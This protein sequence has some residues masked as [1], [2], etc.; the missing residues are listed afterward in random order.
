M[1]AGLRDTDPMSIR[2]HLTA[3][4]L[5][6]ATG[7]STCAF[8]APAAPTPGTD[9]RRKVPGDVLRA[10]QSTLP[11]GRRVRRALLSPTFDPNL[12]VSAPTSV[13]V[14]FLWDAASF[15]NAFGYFTWR[16]GGASGSNIEILDR[17][18]VFA[19]ASRGALRPGDAVKLRDADGNVR[20]FE[21][22]TR[23]GFFV[24]ADGA[25]LADSADLADAPSTDPKVNA[26]LARGV[27]TTLDALN[28]EIAAGQP[29]KARHIAMLSMPGRAGFLKG[30][31]FFVMGMEDARRDAG[32]DQ[33]F[34][35]LVFVVRSTQVDALSDTHVITAAPDVEGDTDPDGDGLHGLQDDF[36]EDA[37]R[38]TVA[39][40]APTTLAGRDAVPVPVATEQVLDAAG[41]VREV[42]ATFHRDAQAAAEVLTLP[43]LPADARGTVFVERFLDT[44]E[45]VAPV[46]A[47]LEGFLQPTAPG[48][49][50]L[51][52]PRLFRAG[53]GGETRVI[54]RLDAPLP[55]WSAKRAF[56]WRLEGAPA[57][58]HGPRKLPATPLLPQVW[59]LRPGR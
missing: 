5:L 46:H 10:V 41:A 28:P 11:D 26:G 20:I 42:V 17:Q 51:R 18:L 38:G 34:N 49:A 31:P 56:P 19:D 35:D 30:Q 1:N 29:G 22:G 59:T 4:A 54:V 21:P 53:E 27:F 2:T 25:G 45:H 58:F 6:L 55:A 8:A 24:V 23:I 36:P 16:A 12:A 37:S 44:G 14:V 9:L 3:A 57:A 7:L 52:Y 13:E 47:R 15:R 48:E 32:A 33:D 39:S 43:G 50:A 40:H